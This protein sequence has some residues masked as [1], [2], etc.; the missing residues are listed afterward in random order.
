MLD[1][2]RETNWSV[3]E[4]LEPYVKEFWDKV[5]EIKKE[6]GKK[7]KDP[8]VPFDTLLR[9]KSKQTSNSDIDD[10]ITLQGL[11]SSNRVW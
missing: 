8:E 11:L 7:G 9:I 10:T 4:A 2:I 3:Y 5:E 1:N 6:R